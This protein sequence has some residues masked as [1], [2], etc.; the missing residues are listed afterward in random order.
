MIS[1]SMHKMEVFLICNIS[2]SL[3]LIDFTAFYISSELQSQKVTEYNCLLKQ[4][5]KRF[6]KGLLKNIVELSEK[7]GI[8]ITLYSP[9][10]PPVY[11][12]LLHTS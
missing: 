11:F 3:E 1:N 7:N 5:P 4:K 6:S 10:I 12:Y 2:D 9:P 8:A